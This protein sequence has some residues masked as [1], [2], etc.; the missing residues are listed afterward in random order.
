MK[1]RNS[2]TMGI[3]L[4]AAQKDPRH[5]PLH[6]PLRLQYRNNAPD[7]HALL[8][9]P[10]GVGVAKLLTDCVR[11]FAT[12]DLDNRMTKV[13]TIDAVDIDIGPSD[14]EPSFIF[15][16]EDIDVHLGTAY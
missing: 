3:V 10:Y 2:A 14:N 12:Y 9:S 7:F 5:A 11:L 1:A 8:G 15:V 4:D 6:Y 13:K 16:M